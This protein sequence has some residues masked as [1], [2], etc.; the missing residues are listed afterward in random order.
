M[1]ILFHVCDEEC[2]G[3]DKPL[4]RKWTI[5][6]YEFERC[7]KRYCDKNVSLI[8][9]IYQHYLRGFLP[10]SGG[11]LNQSNR[12]IELMSFIDNEIE[13]HKSEHGRKN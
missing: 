11:L 12:Y 6:K 10:N 8:W 1:I 13:K 3:D 5:D 2:K 4:K 9:K 7:P